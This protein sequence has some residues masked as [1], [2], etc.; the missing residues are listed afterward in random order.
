MNPHCPPPLT[1]SASTAARKTLAVRV[2]RI[3]AIV[4]RAAVL[5]AIHVAA[6]DASAQIDYGDFR[7]VDGLRFAGTARQND[8]ILEL[9]AVGPKLSGAVWYFQKQPISRGFITSFVF[10]V[11]DT[12]GQ[13]DA[14]GERGGDGIAFVIQ[15]SEPAP[16]GGAGG[17]L[18]YDP[19]RNS[20]AIEFDTYA[21]DEPGFDDPNGNHVSIH[22]TGTGTNSASHSYAIATNT[23]IPNLSDGLAHT[24]TIEYV[25]GALRIYLDGCPGL[26]LALPFD[27][28]RRIALD[29]GRAWVGFTA[30]TGSAW[31][32][33]LLHSWRFNGRPLPAPLR[34]SMCEG[35]AARLTPPGAFSSYLWST[36]ESGSSI[37]VLRPGRYSVDVTDSLGC[38][39]SEHTFVF[40]VVESA[41]PRPQI[42]AVDTLLLCAG[43]RITL[44]AGSYAT[45]LWSTGAAT[46]QLVVTTPGTYWVSVAD[47]LGCTG[48]DSV[49][50]IGAPRPSPTVRIEGPTTFCSGGSVVLDAGA[51][52]ASYRWSNGETTQRVVIRDGGTYTVTVTNAQ[53]CPAISA[54]VVIVVRPRPYPVIDALSATRLCPG[55]RVTLDAGAGY[56]DYRWSNGAT[57]RTI[58][59]D[60]SGTFTVTV[61]NDDGCSGTSQPMVVTRVEA[62]KPEI[63]AS[64]ATRLCSG[65]TV[66]LRTTR[67]FSAYRWST[68]ETTPTIIV[69]RSS[70]FRVEVV[71]SNGCSGLSAELAVRLD[72]IGVLRIQASGSTELCDGESVTLRA[73]AGLASY[74]WSTGDT[75]QSIEVA[76]AA[77]YVIVGTDSSGCVGADSVSVRV[78]AQPVADA[79]ADTAICEGTS[80]TI[81]ATGGELVEWTPA[82]GLSC[83]DC[84]TTVAR[85][86][87]TTTYRAVVSNGGGCVDTAFTTITVLP[88]PDVRVQSG[89]E[90]RAYPG[91][92]VDVPISVEGG[93]DAAGADDFTM[94]VEYETHVMILSGITLEGEMLTGW[95]MQTIEDRPGYFIARF[96]STDGS[97]LRGDRTIVTLR[98]QTF[99]GLPTHAAIRPRMTL[100]GRP[101]VTIGSTDAGV[102]IDSLCGVGQ[103][104]IEG[105]DASYALSQAAPNPF[106][107]TTSIRFSVGSEGPARLEILSSAGERV[108]LLHDGALAAGEHHF[109]WDATAMPSGL[110]FAR[111][112]S[113]EWSATRVL[114][115]VR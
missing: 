73:P 40:D 94:E 112:S 37:D 15:N 113:G 24:V 105:L 11:A 86:A 45:Y 63:T 72:S 16:V 43:S 97:V 111:A 50:I 18:G 56:T 26:L 70:S 103:R 39:P 65:D 64:P 66:T 96:R 101:C 68:G 59:V 38:Q 107:P 3:G 88:A 57:T 102:T 21:N 42:A 27:F 54:P 2:L 20:V 108:A 10:Q 19:I 93:I 83:D 48:R 69:T 32:R 53:G 23:N 62:P 92:I 8:S 82:D 9:N 25:N 47:S 115:L 13:V 99:L 109:D 17:F 28:E 67:P 31:E 14:G 77:T 35:S 52:F 98:M 6:T 49:V 33:H 29:N 100:A 61:T 104:L 46:R 60:S 36:G 91:T 110:Y 34:V 12:S 90:R 95:T 75:T 89:G 80:T 30:A 58:D 74:R 78:F 1:A 79:S 7:S 71:D 55:A 5:I 114:M 81:V 85:P 106:N 51:G 41:N 44:D 84:A 4:A 87:R 76:V 22:T